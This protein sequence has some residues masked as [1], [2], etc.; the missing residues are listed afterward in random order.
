MIERN[1][2]RFG[3]NLSV[4]LILYATFWIFSAPYMYVNG[5]IEYGNSIT[6]F[7]V[8]KYSILGLPEQIYL[9][10]LPIVFLLLI[11]EVFRAIYLISAATVR[12]MIAAASRH[13][14]PNSD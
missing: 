1:L 8:F 10:A 12:A 13:G 3:R 5:I 4:P 14:I 7:W 2:M 9:V 6:D 11:Y